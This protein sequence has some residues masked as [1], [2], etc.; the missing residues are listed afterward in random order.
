MI[1]I[2]IPV[3]KSE[4]TL[5][6]CIECVLS[7]SYRELEIIMVVDGP[8]DS[9]GILADRMALMDERIR[10]IHQQNEGVSAAR[11][12][13]I[14]A[15]KGDYV[16]FVDSDDYLEPDACR[17]MLDAIE[18]GKSDMVIAGFHH[19]YFGQK[20]VKIPNMEGTYTLKA[21]EDVFLE[22]YETQFLNM[23]W[24][25]LYKRKLI[26]ENFL[27]DLSL[28]ED[29]L[30]NIAYMRGIHSFS[31]IKKAVYN[32]IQDDRWTTL[33]TRKRK[34]RIAVSLQL[35][36]EVKKFCEDIFNE[37]D[38]VP[39]RECMLKSK[40]AVEFLDALEALAFEKKD[41]RNKKTT[42]IIEYRKA[43][44]KMQE[45]IKPKLDLLDYK[46]IYYFFIR[47]NI[48]LTYWMILLRG[49]VVRFARSIKTKQ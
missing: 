5:A 45:N 8:P 2:I 12:R 33:S 10:V 35:Y 25:K 44:G 31:V 34:D 28:G 30:F 23:P 29:L 37:S 15:S 9:S 24:N 27:K 4:K 22:L 43:W 13:G 36:G 6:K 19:L 46:I 3:Y 47:N 48:L 17:E 49:M 41:S 16:Q 32:Y 20:I 14:E 26:T 7:Q 40:V 18:N 1:S 11:N 39:K 38:I 42:V 21:K